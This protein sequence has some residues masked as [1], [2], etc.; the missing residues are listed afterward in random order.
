[1]D[2]MMRSKKDVVL[3]G[4]G[5]SS[6]LAE[7]GRAAA[8]KLGLDGPSFRRQILLDIIRI[9]ESGEKVAYPGRVLTERQE[10][11]LSYPR[12]SLDHHKAAL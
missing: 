3:P 8:K 4:L 7:R 6:E 10:R 5:V 9:A 11:I 12:V 2:M 1:M